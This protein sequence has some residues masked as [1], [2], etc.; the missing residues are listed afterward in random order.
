MKQKMLSE[1]IRLIVI[2]ALAFD[3][4]LKPEVREFVQ[5]KLEMLA[6]EYILFKTTFWRKQTAV[7]KKLLFK[8][9]EL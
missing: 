6:D 5:R 7:D 3:Q 2:F 9:V 1:V 4:F 8:L